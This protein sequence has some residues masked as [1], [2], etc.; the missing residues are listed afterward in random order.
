[1]HGLY[2]ALGAGLAARFPGWRLAAIAPERALAGRL[3]P[4]MEELL[5]FKNGGIPVGFYV[6]ELPE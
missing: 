1:M 5:T 3:L 2:R 4:R 6:G